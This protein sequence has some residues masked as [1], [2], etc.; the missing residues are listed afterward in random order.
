MLKNTPAKLLATLLAVLMLV[1]MMPITAFA[2]GS[3]NNYADFLANL[4]QLE[5]YA[6]EFAAQSSRDPG[7]LVLNFIRTGVERYQ[8]G[9]WA[10]LAGQEITA[11]TNYVE[12]Q[13]AANG[14]TAM[15]LRDIVIKDFKL[16]NG[17]PADF[18]HMSGTMNISYVASAVQ[19]DDLAGWAGDLCDLL[20]YSALRSR[21]PNGTIDEMAAYIKEYCF[22]VDADDAFGWDDFY[23][24]MDAFYLVNEYQAGN[25]SFSQLMEDYFTAELND[26]D[27]AVYF[28]NNRF[29]GQ[30]TREAVR[31][32]LYNAYRTNVGIQILEADR[33]LSD[34]SAMRQASCYAL[35]DYLFDHADGKLNAGG[36]DEGEDEEKPENGLYSVFSTTSSVLAPGITQDIKYAMSADGKQMV[37]YV[38]TVDVTRD[39]VTI[40]ANYKDNDPSKGW[41]MQRLE[42][43]VAAMVKNNKNVENFTPVVATNGDGFNTTTGEP[44]GLLVMDGTVWKPIDGDGF[45]GILK[46]G[47]AVIGT[48]EEYDALADQVA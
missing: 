41:G 43:Q 44:A 7:E 35:A 29:P 45:F 48:K 39:D 8:D 33:G 12:E 1:G 28:L 24:D 34:F 17:N 36:G 47:S 31:T 5:V 38:A 9:N 42:D 27:R 22:G 37:Y 13:D 23:G 18:G 30:M 16:P 20:D 21:V 25:G 4:K 14:T 3:V 10:A 15:D 2:A 26:E 40:K 19:S 6:D 11:F 32:A 46:D